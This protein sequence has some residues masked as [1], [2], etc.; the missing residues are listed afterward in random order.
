M[1]T[2]TVLNSVIRSVKANKPGTASV[3]S[4]CEHPITSIKLPPTGVLIQTSFAG[5]NFIDTYYRSGLYSK[6]DRTFPL[7][8]GEEGSGTI[9]E[10]GSEV[11]ERESWLNQRVAFFKNQTGSYSSFTFADISQVFRI[12]DGVTDAMAAAVILQGC[13]AHYLTNDTFPIK[14]GDVALV[15]AA[16]GGTG[17]LISQ[18]AKL[19]GATVIGICGSEAKVKLA[20]EVGNCDHVIDY[21]AT[22]DWPAA[23]KALCPTGVHVVFDGVGQATFRGSLS[24]LRPRGVMV[25]FGNASGAVDP[26]APLE[27]SKAGSVYL[28]RPILKDYCLTR[29]EAEGRVG[30]V[31][32]MVKDGS[33]NVTICSTMGLDKAQEAHQLLEG[34]GSS[35]KILINCQE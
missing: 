32:R 14:K 28:T 21:V 20:T 31:F 15:H 19:R 17:L 10:V 3:L 4:V 34:R 26:I 1:K 25:S 2:T 29:E 6:P 9:I 8:I 24:C 18:M 16:A 13:T 5:V 35:G 22:A 33:I 11:A 7:D 27:L 30:D 12:P 23:V